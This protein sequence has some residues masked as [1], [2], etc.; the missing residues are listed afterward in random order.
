MGAKWLLAAQK[1]LPLGYSRI[2]TGKS[3]TLHEK[4]A[5]Q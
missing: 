5:K 4:L 1:G 2:D 3:K